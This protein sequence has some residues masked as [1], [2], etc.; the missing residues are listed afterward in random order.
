MGMGILI[1]GDMEGLEVP[2]LKPTSTGF[3]RTYIA[4]SISIRLIL[5]GVFSYIG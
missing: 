2:S 1:T 5:K 3:Q 4:E